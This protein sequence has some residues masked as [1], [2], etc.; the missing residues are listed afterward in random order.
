MLTMK[1][2]VNYIYVSK[3]DSLTIFGHF[4][5]HVG[6]DDD[7]DVMMMMMIIKMMMMMVS[8]K[9][10][11]ECGEGSSDSRTRRN[12]ASNTWTE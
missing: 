7:D 6:D 4:I 9:K 3:L 1:M 12:I 2:N 11:E 5:N 8:N 10:G